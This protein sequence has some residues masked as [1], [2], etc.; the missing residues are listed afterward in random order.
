MYLTEGK[1]YQ[2]HA[3]QQSGPQSIWWL[4]QANTLWNGFLSRFPFLI[5]KTTLTK[6]ILAR[7]I[8]H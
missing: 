3:T 5:N 2:K 6:T 4:I 8:V 1:L 7:K